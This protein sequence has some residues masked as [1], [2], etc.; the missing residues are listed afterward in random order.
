MTSRSQP[1]C[2]S[3][4]EDWG[5]IVHRCWHLEP[6]WHQPHLHLLFSSPSSLIASACWK[7]HHPSH[8]LRQSRHLCPAQSSMPG[9]SSTF[10]KCGT[11]WSQRTI[12]PSSSQEQYMPRTKPDYWPLDLPT[13]ETGFTRHPLPLWV[14]GCRTKPSGSQLLTDLDARPVNRTAA[15]VEKQWMLWAYMVCP[16]AR[17]AQTPSSSLHERHPLQGN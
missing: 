17:A 1:H 10:K 3:G 7:T 13:Q 12:K 4:T 9:K 5:S 16:A 11:N 15:Y 14:S 8:P 6:F 2:Q